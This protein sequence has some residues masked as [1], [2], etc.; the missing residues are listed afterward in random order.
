MVLFIPSRIVL[1]LHLFVFFYSSQSDIDL[2]CSIHTSPIK[3]LQII[4]YFISIMNAT[5][6]IAFF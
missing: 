3:F 5:F 4:L 2:I 6:F 1:P